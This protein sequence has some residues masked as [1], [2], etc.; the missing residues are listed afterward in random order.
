MF[1]RGDFFMYIL[2][3]N[4]SPRKNSNVSFLINEVL[5]KCAQMGAKTEEVYVADSLATAKFPFCVVCSNPCSGVCYRGTGLEELFE[6]MKKAD[7]L[8]FGSPVYFGSMSAQLKALFDKTRRLRGEKAFV[9]KPCGFIAVGASRFGGQEAT[10]AAMHAM[11][12]VQGMTVLGTGHPDVD[13]GH[14]GISA[15]QP[16][17]DDE[18][19]KSRC[20]SLALRIMELKR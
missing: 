6:K 5:D 16:A 12:L 18:F 8:I 2:A 4:A 13:A 17:K 9:G 10:I 15:Q 1:K 20:K 14:L 11:A 7:A 19:A 3:L